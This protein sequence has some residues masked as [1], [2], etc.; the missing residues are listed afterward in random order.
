VSFASQRA[1]IVYFVID[2]VRK[3]LDTSWYLVKQ[4]IRLHGVLLS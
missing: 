1:F 3:L 2:W 4:R